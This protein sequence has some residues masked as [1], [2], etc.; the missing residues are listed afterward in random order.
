MENSIKRSKEE[1]QKVEKQ[2][3]EESNQRKKPRCAEAK[4]CIP[5][6]TPKHAE[7]DVVEKFLSKLRACFHISDCTERN[8]AIQNLLVNLEY[9]EK[10]W[11]KYVHFSSDRYTRSL[12]AA[13]PNFSVLL[14]CWAN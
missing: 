5:I 3:E 1:E 2:A 7:T 12:V 9:S 4:A 11:E 8:K 10:D 14:L 6:M 13:E